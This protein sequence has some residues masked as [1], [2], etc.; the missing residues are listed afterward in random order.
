ME[1]P[2][3]LLFSYKGFT[4][5]K[6]SFLQRKNNYVMYPILIQEDYP[7]NKNQVLSRVF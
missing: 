5:T 2:H 4:I 6:E 3:N 1:I 7:L